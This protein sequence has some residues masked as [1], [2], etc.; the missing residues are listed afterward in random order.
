LQ[1]VDLLYFVVDE[2]GEVSVV[3]V[4]DMAEDGSGGSV[5]LKIDSPGE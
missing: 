1:D 2:V 5:R 3:N 4:H